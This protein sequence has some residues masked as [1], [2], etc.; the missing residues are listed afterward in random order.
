MALSIRFTLSPIAINNMQILS[1]LSTPLGVVK[2]S[3]GESI[4]SDLFNI[5]SKAVCIFI[6]EE[7]INSVSYINAFLLDP[8]SQKRIHVV[9]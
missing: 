1:N 8:V 3:S 4:V 9:P 5:Q 7:R 6:K 2:K